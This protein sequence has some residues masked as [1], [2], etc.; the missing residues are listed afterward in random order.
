MSAGRAEERKS[1]LGRSQTPMAKLFDGEVEV[2]D[3]SEGQSEEEED[4]DDVFQRCRWNRE[5][6]LVE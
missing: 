5:E 4:D 1:V 2:E 6:P 3:Q